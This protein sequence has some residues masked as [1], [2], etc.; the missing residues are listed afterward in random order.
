MIELYIHICPESGSGSLSKTPETRDPI[1]L[2][3]EFVLMIG[4]LALVLS[5][6]S[7]LRKRRE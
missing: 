2:L 5:T 6:W 3:K 1:D 4:S 7:Q